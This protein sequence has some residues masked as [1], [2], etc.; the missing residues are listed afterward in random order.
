MLRR[1]ASAAA[2]RTLSSSASSSGLKTLSVT[3]DKG[4]VVIKGDHD[5]IKLLRNVGFEY[6][7]ASHSWTQ[8][9]AQ[10]VQRIGLAEGAVLD[11]DAIITAALAAPSVDPSDV[12][13]AAAGAASGDKPANAA[14][15]PGKKEGRVPAMEVTSGMVRIL[16]AYSIKDQLKT[17]G[18]L[19]DA[20]DKVWWI[21][22]SDYEKRIGG[23][24]S[25]EA[26]LDVAKKRDPEVAF[27]G[28]MA[29]VR[30]S[31]AIK[32]A[33]K[34]AGFRFH[35]ADGT[36][37]AHKD[38]FQTYISAEPDMRELQDYLAHQGASPV[39]ELAEVRGALS[40]EKGDQCYLCGQTGHWARDC[41]NKQASAAYDG[42]AAAPNPP[43][44]GIGNKPAP[45][46]SYKGTPQVVVRDGVISV[47]NCFEHKDKLRVVGFRWNKDARTWDMSEAAF[48]ADV[49]PLP[50]DWAALDKLLVFSVDKAEGDAAVARVREDVG[51]VIAGA[52]ER[53]RVLG[54]EKRDGFYELGERELLRELNA[55]FLSW[56]VLKRALAASGE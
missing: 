19:W 42:A 40:N 53:L 37:L 2:S 43:G 16:N 41:P 44:A 51:D 39:A 52:D 24:K 14:A 15:T 17:V 46:A 12:V 33:L 23:V 27:E 5:S 26:L 32:D 45:G 34:R 4:N 35:A 11:K 22:E 29:V 10:L 20:H 8:N 25:M 36:W 1:L 56:G 9:R 48:A 31:Y 30:H 13:A 49:G 3:M 28:D 21:T 47:S 50:A 55:P 54:F 7:K 38:W 6:N 18:F